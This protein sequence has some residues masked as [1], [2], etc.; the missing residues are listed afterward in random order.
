M[1]HSDCDTG[2]L[3]W[4]RLGALLSPRVRLLR[5]ALT[6]RSIAA[7]LP[8]GLPTGSL[9]VLSLIAANP[10]SSQAALARR[11]GINKSALVGI[12]DHLEAQG[13][14]ARDRSEVDRRRNTL[15]VTEAGLEAMNRLFAA[16]AAI[17]TPIAEALGESDMALLIGLL[18]RANAALV[19]AEGGCADTE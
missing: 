2:D 1:G 4:G 19:D 12:V 8:S 17:E 15:T 7:T 18:E 16:V 11:A 10:R 3:N 13:L 6:A 14:A 9:T 5:N